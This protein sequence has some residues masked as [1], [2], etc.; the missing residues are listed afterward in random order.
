MML[1]LHALLA[2]DIANERSREAACLA[3]RRRTAE[4][5]AAEVAE[6]P[7]SFVRRPSPARLAVA[8][9]LHAVE[10]GAASVARSAGDAASRVDGSCA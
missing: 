6:H 2:I 1:P 7:S 4:L 5:A 3:E 10:G 9:V 8:R